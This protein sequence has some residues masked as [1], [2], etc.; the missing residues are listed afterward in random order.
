MFT[1]LVD[2]RAA[3]I[4]LGLSKQIHGFLANPPTIAEVW[5]L[6]YLLWKGVRVPTQDAATISAGST[7]PVELTP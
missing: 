7:G 6:E 4:A 5:M 2:M 1:A 3:F